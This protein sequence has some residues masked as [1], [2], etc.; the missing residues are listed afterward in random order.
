MSRRLVHDSLCISHRAHGERR[1]LEVCVSF[2]LFIKPRFRFTIHGPGRLRE[3]RMGR[4]GKA[5][6]RD[7]DTKRREGD[8]SRSDTKTRKNTESRK[9]A[10]IIN[11]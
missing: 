2:V 6:A 5:R 11:T 4:K 10:V 8:I 1:G 7:E 9:R 3:R